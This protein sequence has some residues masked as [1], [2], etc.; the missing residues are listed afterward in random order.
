MTN[1]DKRNFDLKRRTG[2]R[3]IKDLNRILT[4]IGGAEQAKEKM[5]EFGFKQEA[6]DD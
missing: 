1:G 6:E 3:D 5:K 2:N 4:D